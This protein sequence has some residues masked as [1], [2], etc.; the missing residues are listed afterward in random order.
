MIDPKL[1]PAMFCQSA[2]GAA[3]ALEQIAAVEERV[4]P[5][6]PTLCRMGFGA[7]GARGATAGV[8]MAAWLAVCAELPFFGTGRGALVFPAEAP[9]PAGAAIFRR[10][11]STGPHIT[12]K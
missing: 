9:V 7:H 6:A 11:P 10:L 1:K 8:G 3:K 5:L 4:K 2:E 12:M